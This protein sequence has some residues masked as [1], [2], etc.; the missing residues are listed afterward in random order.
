[1]ALGCISRILSKAHKLELMGSER[2]RRQGDCWV[3]EELQ[4]SYLLWQAEKL[5]ALSVALSEALFRDDHGDP[6]RVVVFWR[7]P[8]SL[9]LRRRRNP[10]FVRNLHFHSRTRR[11]SRR[12]GGCRATTRLDGKG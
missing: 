11:G 8:G 6:S 3:Y 4:R 5:A 12:A 1:M 10:D 7:L 2:E 9:D